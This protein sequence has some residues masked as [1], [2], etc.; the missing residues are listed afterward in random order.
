MKTQ[1]V[2]ASRESTTR[3]PVRLYYLDWLRVLGILA[4]FVYHSTRLFNMEEWLVKNPTWYP[5]VEVWNR[6]ATAWLMPLMFVI[7]G[8]SL[9]YALGKGEGGIKGAGAFVKDKA[10]R[11]LVPWLAFILTHQSLQF[12]LNDLS[13]GRFSGP[14]F[15]YLPEYYPGSLDLYG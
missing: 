6:F 13:H 8:A 2:S 14:Y 9:F 15:Q 3:G 7:S 5:W 4:V 12:Y 1:V 11:L 10:L